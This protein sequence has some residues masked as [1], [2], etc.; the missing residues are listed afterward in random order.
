MKEILP[1]CAFSLFSGTD[2]KKTQGQMEMENIIRMLNY[3][4][5]GRIV[6]VF[7]GFAAVYL[8]LKNSIYLYLVSRDFRKEVEEG[9]LSEDQLRSYMGSNPMIDIIQNVTLVHGSHSE[10]LRAEVA[11]LFQQ[12]F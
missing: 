3:D 10:D 9:R 6:L 7:A 11:Y 4:R 12:E 2:R 5:S 1:C 8:V